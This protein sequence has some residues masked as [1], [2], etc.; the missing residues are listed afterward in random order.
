VLLPD[1]AIELTF[2]HI[3]QP[4]DPRRNNLSTDGCG[5]IPRGFIADRPIRR[6]FAQLVK[7]TRTG[8]LRK[9][10]AAEL[11]EPCR[12]N[13]ACGP[14]V[15]SSQL[16]RRHH[17]QLREG[18]CQIHLTLSRGPRETLL[19]F[20]LIGS[21]FLVFWRWSLLNWHARGMILAAYGV[22]L[23]LVVLLPALR[24]RGLLKS[25][26]PAE[27]A[28]VGS[29]QKTSTDKD[30]SPRP[31][32]VSSGSEAPHTWP[33][34]SCA[35]A[36]CRCGGPA[37]GMFL[38]LGSRRL[39]RASS[40]SRSIPTSTARRSGWLRLSPSTPPTARSRGSCLT[41]R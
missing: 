38:G 26:A 34:R 2:V 18:W 15:H 4:F 19:G 28:V 41:P 23:L 12:W 10:C 9:G 37:L 24:T 22:V 17:Y 33:S 29:E 1:E 6:P 32:M 14:A 25:G 27:G 13:G 39:A 7:H 8:L 20:L 35:T 21:V 30:G 31:S 3:Q 11:L 40:R 16:V 5:R 36:A